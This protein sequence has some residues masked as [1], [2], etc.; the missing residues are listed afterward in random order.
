MQKPLVNK[1]WEEL[2]SLLPLEKTKV[3]S[4]KEVIQEAQKEGR[5]VHFATLMDICHLKNSEFGPK[6]LKYKDVLLSEET[7]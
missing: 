3:R 4:K 6:Y 5:T 7:W 1:G 2:E